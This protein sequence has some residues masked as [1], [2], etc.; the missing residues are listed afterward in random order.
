MK[1]EAIITTRDLS[2][3][4][5]GGVAALSG[6][7]LEIL[8]GEF[9]AI[10][11]SNGS[12]KTTLAKHFNGLLKPSQGHVIVDGLDTRTTRVSE[13]SRIVGFVFQNPDHQIF[14]Y[15]VWEEA[16]FGLKL[17]RVDEESI[18]QQTTDALR[19]VAL[20]GLRDRHPR[21]L[22]RGQRQRLATASILALETPVLVL[23]EPTTGQDFISR[24]QIM[25]LTVDLHAEGRTVIMVTH[26]MS[27]V[28]EYASRVIVMQD[29]KVLGDSPPKEAFEREEILMSTGLELPPVIRIARGLREYG[30]SDTPLTQAELVEN[31]ITAIR[32]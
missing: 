11:G 20:D 15:S 1:S 7:S 24:R 6:V 23:D 10:I 27:L 26:D 9:I 14:G 29:G 19:A 4:Y 13:L 28:A 5:P 3:S 32:R 22:S 8:S 25:E 18:E 31:L 30:F 16:S 2:Y 17:Q 21:A 12:G